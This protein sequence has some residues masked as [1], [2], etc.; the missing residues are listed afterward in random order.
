VH[1]TLQSFRLTPQGLLKSLDY[2]KLTGFTLS[3]G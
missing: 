3:I 2:A 1:T